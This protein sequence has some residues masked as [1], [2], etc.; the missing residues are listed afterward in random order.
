MN[1]LIIFAVSLSLLLSFGCTK[2]E[3]YYITEEAETETD[4]QQAAE[5]EAEAEITL[6][7]GV[8]SV[9]FERFDGKEIELQGN[10]PI[11]LRAKLIVV[12]E[13]ALDAEDKGNAEYLF[14]LKDGK[15]EKIEGNFEWDAESKTMAFM[16]GKNLRY[17]TDYTIELTEVIGSFKTM[18]NGDVD[19][20]GVADVVVG[21]PGQGK[22]YI[23][24]GAHLSE[25]VDTYYAGGSSFGYG[26][27]VAIVGDVNADGYDDVAVGEPLGSSGKG[28]V[29]VISGRMF[30]KASPEYLL[31]TIPGEQ[32]NSNLGDMVAG[33]GDV[34]NDGYWD[35]LVSAPMFS[36]NTAVSDK[37]G[38]AL[39][40]DGK[41]LA[42]GINATIK[43]WV[44]EENQA[45]LG[46]NV[47]SAGDINGDGLPELAIA[48][49]GPEPGVNIYD[50]KNLEVPLRKISVT[51]GQWFGRPTTA[52]GDLDGDSK[53]DLLIS[54]FGFSAGKG[55][56]Y[57]YSGRTIL[58]EDS[59]PPK[60]ITGVNPTGVLG[61]S[62][63]VMGEG[64]EALI[65]AGS[66]STAGIV[67]AYRA[68]D[69]APGDND[70]GSYLWTKTYSLANDHFGFAMSRIGDVTNDGVDDLIIG[71]P[72][73]P[74][75]AEPEGRAMIYS[76][77][78]LNG[79]SIYPL[80]AG[81]G[82]DEF[83]Y[84]VSG[85]SP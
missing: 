40:Y 48:E 1:K 80:S 42:Q 54:D 34:N 76:G 67:Y 44:G 24:S 41:M 5:A 50:P 23:V 68:K 35:L 21:A 66:L 32:D 12:F 28:S 81:V 55:K 83:G 13:E 36:V 79:L 58:G 46:F 45:M 84:S 73:S 30:A 59:T 69:L 39:L 17:Q 11:P 14:T 18:I 16:P 71:S 65:L 61:I 3:K 27:S 64:D 25:P 62:N 10:N 82:S 70:P 15:G 7:V 85:L 63:A 9:K 72:K 8:E 19:G 77:T 6:D 31:T 52:A 4:L 60:T 37:K 33:A 47:A 74:V 20:D 53:G 22:V 78:N 57:L 56:I 2:V 38:K 43:T 51:G 29:F 26:S 75:C 49:I